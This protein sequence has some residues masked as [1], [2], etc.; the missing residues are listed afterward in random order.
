MTEIQGGCIGITALADRLSVST[1][2]V[3]RIV[4]RG[5]LPVVRIGRRVVIRLA[6]VSR[7]LDGRQ[8]TPTPSANV[9]GIGR[10]FTAG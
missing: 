8:T 4:D 3:R 9:T 1:R 10:R 6:E 5:E 7:W 2:T